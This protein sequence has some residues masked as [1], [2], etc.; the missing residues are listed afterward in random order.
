M[1]K[2]RRCAK[3]KNKGRTKIKQIFLDIPSFDC[4]LPRLDIRLSFSFSDRILKVHLIILEVLNQFQKPTSSIFASF[5]FHFHFY[6][7]FFLF[8]FIFFFFHFLQALQK[9]ESKQKNSSLQKR[10]K[11][12]NEKTSWMMTAASSMK[13]PQEPQRNINPTKSRPSINNW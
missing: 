4:Q 3:K 9:M 11:N 2:E 6:F 10:K 13:S 5:H 12:A 8:Y 7:H 1:V